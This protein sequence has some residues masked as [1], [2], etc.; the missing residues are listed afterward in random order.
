MPPVDPGIGP[1]RAGPQLIQGITPYFSLTGTMH[2][3]PGQVNTN[4]DNVNIARTG[5]PTFGLGC[6]TKHENPNTETTEKTHR[7]MRPGLCPTHSASR[8]RR[9]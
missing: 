9:Q 4:V 7:Y 8:Y 1:E 3:K 2:G 6:L 5:C